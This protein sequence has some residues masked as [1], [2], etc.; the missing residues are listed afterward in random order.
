[1]RVCNFASGSKGNCTYIESDNAKVLV[2]IG[3]SAKYVVDNLTELNINPESIDAILITHE[4]SDHIKGVINFAKKYRTKILCA[5]VLEDV[6]NTQLIGCAD[7]IETY[8]G[9][10]EIGDLRVIPFPLSHDSVA[11][12]GYKFIDGDASVSLATDLG[13]CPENVFRIINSSAVVFLEANYDPE[14]L[15]A[16][17]YPPFLKKRIMGNYG[18]LSNKDCALVAEKL[19]YS[20]TRQIVLSHISENSNTQFLAYT[21]VKNYLE[22]RGVIVG[23]NV[24]LDVANQNC[25]G[26]IYKIRKTI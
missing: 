26:T 15:F 25:R 9:E 20:G 13:F 14:M 17:N 8:A 19:A 6:L 5:E 16:C 2:D 7:L 21:T 4:H 10:F 3:V 1:M 18:H 23:Q 22:S 24:R 11:C 12:F